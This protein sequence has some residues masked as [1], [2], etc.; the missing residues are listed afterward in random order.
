MY[1][2]QTSRGVGSGSELP[3]E[4]VLEGVV[5]EFARKETVIK[6]QSHQIEDDSN[7]D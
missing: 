3:Y 7:I 6:A 5:K 1:E 4:K 2:A